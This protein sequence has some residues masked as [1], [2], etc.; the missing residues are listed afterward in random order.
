MPINRIMEADL[1][2]RQAFFPRSRHNPLTN[3]AP[4]LDL[5]PARGSDPAFL[6][7]L[8]R[9][10]RTAG[11]WAELLEV[12]LMQ[13]RLRHGLPVDAPSLAAAPAEARAQLEQEY[14]D[15]CE[16]A[17]LGLLGQRRWRDAWFYLNT[18]GKPAAMRNALA[19]ATPAGTTTNGGV[20]NRGDAEANESE[21]D[22]L[23]EVALHDGADPPRGFR[24]LIQAYGTCNAVTSLEGMGPHLSVDALAGCA[25]VLAGHLHDELVENLRG[26]IEREEGR[27]PEEAKLPEIVDA[28]DWLF[29]VEAA[30]VDA[31]HL[32][33]TVRIARVLDQP[34]QVRTAWELADYGRRLHASLHYADA[35]PFEDAYHAH[36]LF[37]A[38]Q[39]GDRVD[40]ATAYFRDKADAAKP[41]V[42]GLAALETLLVLLHRVG[43]SSE[44]IAEYGRLAPA[45]VT[46]SPYAP[47]PLDLARAS[48]AWDA[49][50]DAM[51]ARGDVVGLA[52]AAI[53][54]GEG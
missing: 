50:R 8:A 45:G 6:A 14:T 23:I 7:T 21:V 31:S 1:G 43:R 22:E 52:Q 12:R 13:A 27:P 44:A 37:Y 35:P 24:W 48:G 9:R 54:D 20:A 32:S 19:A 15:A 53:A 4:L 39:L 25:A 41:E 49:L 18:A 17:G 26:H 51:R 11:R 33:A 3:E 38:A 5:I 2:A 34:D 40:E 46:L 36:E 47:R 30:H 42:E 16:E 10:L 28:R 29:A